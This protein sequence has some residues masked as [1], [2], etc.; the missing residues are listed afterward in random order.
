MTNDAREML[1]KAGV[2]IIQNQQ[3]F[4]NSS[5]SVQQSS[6]LSSLESGLREVAGIDPASEVFTVKIA[7]GPIDLVTANEIRTIITTYGDKAKIVAITDESGCAEDPNGLDHT[8]LLRLIDNKATIAS[9]D[10]SKLSDGLAAVHSFD[11]AEGK[12]AGET[13]LSRVEAD[14]FLPLSGPG[15]IVDAQCYK[16]LI[17]MDGK[18]SAK[19]IIE[20]TN[21]RVTAKAREKLEEE[22]GMAVQRQVTPL[23]AM[24][25]AQLRT[26]LDI[27]PTK[28]AF[29]IKLT[30]GPADESAAQEIK[31]L[32]REYGDK[33]KFVAIADESGC[34]E[35]GNGIGHQELLRLVEE[36]KTISEYDKK[37][38]SKEGKLH[39]ASTADGIK[40]RNSMPHRV[41]SDV[42]IPAG[43]FSGSSIDINNY[44]SF[45]QADGSPSAAIIIEPSAVSSCVS[46]EAR[47]R[48]LD[49]AGVQVFSPSALSPVEVSRSAPLLVGTPM[50]TRMVDADLT[51]GQDMKTPGRSLLISSPGDQDVSMMPL[52]DDQALTSPS[53]I[54]DP[55]EESPYKHLDFSV[56]SDS[57]SSLGSL[58]DLTQDDITVATTTLFNFLRQETEN[59]RK[60]FE[61]SERAEREALEG[62]GSGDNASVHTRQSVMSKESEEIRTATQ[63]AELMAKTM[64][65]ATS[66]IDG[67]G[68]GMEDDGQV[69]EFGDE[70]DSSPGRLY[71]IRQTG[72]MLD[73]GIGKTL[74]FFVF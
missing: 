46:D 38:L 45:V 14:A 59:I 50:S 41:K 56:N 17:T 31:H 22:T 25:D 47:A 3:N 12:T 10:T 15:S 29:S 6:I 72:D 60:M 63:Q 5:R 49:E 21:A 20:G 52:A 19:I 70:E 23:V 73:F 57:V 4:V 11:T 2:A 71:S 1:Q 42:Y 26:S 69:D 36:G 55:I 74:T 30:G 43:N 8:E 35:D 32:I 68:E 39:L 66:W 54:D 51:D 9:F 33:V 48:L 67:A 27:D 16:K 44:R 24:L 62:V 7:G 28:K 65:Q 40:A 53:A 58:G 64:A 34:V 61:E 13:M 37:Q 18:A